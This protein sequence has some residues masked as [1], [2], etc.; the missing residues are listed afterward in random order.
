MFKQ[1]TLSLAFAHAQSVALAAPAFFVAPMRTRTGG[2]DDPDGDEQDELRRLM[3]VL[4]LV[5]TIATVF[6]Q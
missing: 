2:P 5:I 6:G 1:G 3:P 4:A